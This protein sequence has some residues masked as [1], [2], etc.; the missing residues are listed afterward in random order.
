MERNLYLSEKKSPLLGSSSQG[1]LSHKLLI[2]ASTRSNLHE[3]TTT[4][5]LRFWIRKF[6]SHRS[7]RRSM[8]KTKLDSTSAILIRICFSFCDLSQIDSHSIT[9]HFH[10]IFL[11]DYQ[12]NRWQENDN[13][14]LCEHFIEDII[15]GLL[16]HGKIKTSKG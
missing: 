9:F 14:V 5:K 15:V 16:S 6:L 11:I 8:S 4:K 2:N 1:D 12:Q 13:Q 3:Q 7:H 10:W